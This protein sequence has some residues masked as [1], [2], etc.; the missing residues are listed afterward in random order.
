MAKIFSTYPWRNAAW[1]ERVDVVKLPS[2]SPKR[3]VSV[4][5]AA[6][7]HD[8]LVLNGFARADLLAAGLVA[9]L[10]RPPFIVILD[11]TWSKGGSLVD[12]TFCR[13]A[14]RVFDGDHV[15]YGVLSQ[16]EA[17]SFPRTWEVDAARVHK[18]LWSCTLSDKELTA[19]RSVGGGV[20][21]GGNSLRDWDLMLRAASAVPGPITIASPTLTAK[22]L[23][24]APANVTAGPVSA[25]RYDELLRGADIVVV[26]MQVH[27]DRSSG[28]GT[29]LAAMALGKPLVVNDAPGVRDY[30][31][32]GETGIIVPR[33][34]PDSLAEALRRLL[35]DHQ[36]RS[37]LGA[38]AERDVQQRFLLPHYVQRVL[39]LLDG[40]PSRAQTGWFRSR[41]VRS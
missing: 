22:Q 20:F 11:P 30:V 25:A 3:M 10:P 33:D 2:S 38:A 9:R 18:V 4:L 5:Q 23:A 1:L 21:A 28:Q 36:L 35:A 14:L 39:Q 27:D 29:M 12:R 8:V 41:P 19:P 26:P 24:T 31:T 16:F 17:A 6:L 7:T 34:D 37:R 13:T 32:D 15:H 40:L